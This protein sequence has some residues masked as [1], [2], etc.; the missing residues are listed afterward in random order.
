MNEKLPE[1]VLIYRRVNLWT[2]VIG[3][4]TI[5]FDSLEQAYYY[6]NDNYDE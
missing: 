5:D 3:D 4:K 6:I 1:R 2:V